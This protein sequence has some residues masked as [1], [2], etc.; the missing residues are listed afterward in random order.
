[1]PSQSEGWGGL[2]KG[3]RSG[4]LMNFREAHRINKERFAEI[5][6]VASRL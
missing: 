4:F 1:M 2:F 6:K 5:H 3:P